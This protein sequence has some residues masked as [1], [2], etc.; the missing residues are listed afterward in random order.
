MRKRQRSKERQTPVDFCKFK[1]SLIYKSS[2]GQPVLHRETLSL[3][4][5]KKRKKKKKKENKE[6]YIFP[7]RLSKIELSF[8][9]AT[10]VKIKA[11]EMA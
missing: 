6:R 5:K 10:E 4:N 2:P 9:V 3:C 8:L 1:V 7:L 11:E